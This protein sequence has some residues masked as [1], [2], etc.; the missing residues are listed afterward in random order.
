MNIPDWFLKRRVLRREDV[1]EELQQH[2][3]PKALSVSITHTETQE[4][5][6][7]SIPASKNLDAVKVLARLVR[8]LW[9]RR[10]DD[11]EKHKIERY[12]EERIA[13]GT[14]SNAEV[15]SLGL[16]DNNAHSMSAEELRMRVELR[17]QLFSA[18]E[19]PKADPSRPFADRVNEL[20]SKT[21]RYMLKREQAKS[22]SSRGSK[23]LSPVVLAE[24][25]ATI[26]AS[27]STLRPS[28]GNTFPAT[29]TNLILHSP[30]PDH[31]FLV[32]R[33][34]EAIALEMTLS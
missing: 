6:T 19:E 32:D 10:L 5:A 12:L 28:I 22:R 7:C 25:R 29:K 2:I 31:E 30:V 17:E 1:P 13:A 34:V 24:V 11:Q 3:T 18:T 20:S 8:G 27:L 33:A 21:Q 23:R 26:A 15:E 16:V 4:S 14:G 9:G